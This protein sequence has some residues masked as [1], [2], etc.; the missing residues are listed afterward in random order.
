MDLSWFDLNN[1]YYYQLLL[2]LILIYM[3]QIIAVIGKF[4]VEVSY[5]EAN[6]TDEFDLSRGFWT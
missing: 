5:S 6:G 2:L 1:Y 4:F 3:Y